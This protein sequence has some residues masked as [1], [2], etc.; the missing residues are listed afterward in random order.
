MFFFLHQC[1][2]A[3]R[4]RKATFINSDFPVD[5]A[6]STFQYVHKF[7]SELFEDITCSLIYS[8]HEFINIDDM[9]M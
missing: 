8:F 9:E 3:L 4:D 1:T 7:M 2:F 5:G 6:L